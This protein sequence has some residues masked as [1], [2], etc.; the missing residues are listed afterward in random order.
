M[1]EEQESIDSPILKINYTRTYE[2]DNVEKN[3]F[4][5]VIHTT[6][7]ITEHILGIEYYARRSIFDSVESIIN[8]YNDREN[9]NGILLENAIQIAKALKITGTR[10]ELSI[11]SIQA[12]R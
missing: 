5:I 3:Y 2:D 1:V 10:Y 12:Y 9:D 11:L 8:N 7:G 6:N 4:I